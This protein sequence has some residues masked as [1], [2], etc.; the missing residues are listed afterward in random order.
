[1]I[2]KCSRNNNSNSFNNKTIKINKYKIHNNKIPNILSNNSNSNFNLKL[3]LRRHKV[4]N[5][6]SLNKML[7]ARKKELRKKRIKK[8]N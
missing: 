7:K 3:N 5:S 4:F 6:K 1:M 8:V 2:S